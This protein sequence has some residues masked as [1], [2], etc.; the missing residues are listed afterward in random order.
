M[1]PLLAIA[2]IALLAVFYALGIIFFETGL[3]GVAFGAGVWIA[4]LV[5]QLVWLLAA[6]AFVLNMRHHWRLRM[7]CLALYAPLLVLA[8]AFNMRYQL[9]DVAGLR[10]KLGVLSSNDVVLANLDGLPPARDEVTWFDYLPA[11]EDQGTCSSCWAHAAA[12]VMSSKANISSSLGLV[13]SPRSVP[14]VSSENMQFSHASAQQMIDRDPVIP[15]GM[16]QLSGKCYASEAT[17]GFRI[18]Q[19]VDI[20]DPHCYPS[21]SNL[22]P[23]CDG[24]CFNSDVSGDKRFCTTDAVKVLGSCPNAEGSDAIT[25]RASKLRLIRG[26]AKIQKEISARG[27]VA[28]LVNFYTK[29]D[30]SLPIWTLTSHN[31]AL[32]IP[33]GFVAK[34]EMDGDEYTKEPK[35]GYHLLTVY[36][37]GDNGTKYWNVR[38]SWGP[39]W[40]ASGNTKIERGV[41]AWGI[42]SAGCY[43]VD[44]T[45]NMNK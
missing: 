38:N 11:V 37:Y 25:L 20:M 21:G 24:S 9:F 36:G 42:E 22:S 12:V 43:T 29:S 2:C 14:C 33:D 30:W 39:N 23:K 16:G 10:F 15:L 19:S 45:I 34:P 6:L 8:Y 31:K 32:V 3:V 1:N 7:F 5:C 4:L 18:A 13:K 35:G 40:G 17:S 26:E 28:C 44:V 41:D 27:P